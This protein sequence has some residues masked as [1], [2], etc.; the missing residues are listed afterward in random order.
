M[1]PHMDQ[2]YLPLPATRSFIRTELLAAKLPTGVP[3]Y[4]GLFIERLR[5]TGCAFLLH[6]QP[7]GAEGSMSLFTIIYVS[8]PE[9]NLCFSIFLWLNYVFPEQQHEPKVSR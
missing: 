8:K 9:C 7:P 2:P 5:A 3:M 6:N 4:N 1:T